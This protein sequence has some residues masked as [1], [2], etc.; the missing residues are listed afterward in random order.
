MESSQS[1]ALVADSFRRTA[2]AV[3]CLRKLRAEPVFAASF[4]GWV[5]WL[6]RSEPRQRFKGRVDRTH[7]AHAW[8]ATDVLTFGRLNGYY[9]PV[10][11]LWSTVDNPL[12]PAPPAGMRWESALVPTE[13]LIELVGTARQSL[14]GIELEASPGGEWPVVFLA[15]KR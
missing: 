9:Q 14:L 8:L 1:R 2:Q 7:P 3:E 12:L 10:V 5:A 6:N 15:G 11:A 4:L 13:E